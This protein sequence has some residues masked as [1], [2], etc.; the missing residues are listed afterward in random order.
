MTP[1]TTTFPT[2]TS[3]EVISPN[4][5]ITSA[6][7]SSDTTTKTTTT[8]PTPSESILLNESSPVLVQVYGNDKCLNAH[9]IDVLPAYRA[10][11]SQFATPDFSSTLEN[12]CGTNLDSKGVWYS[13]RSE[14][15]RVVRLEYELK[16]QDLGDSILSIFKGDCNASNLSCIGYTFGGD[17]W[18]GLNEVAIY[19]FLTE[20]GETYRIL[21]SGA[22]P[23]AAGNYEFR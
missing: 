19:E 6:S 22:T 13:L 3:S 15:R 12:T 20:I 5:I 2:T 14:K 10:G 8:T 4:E 11:S 23:N 7:I 21:L 1:Q 9:S 16:T 17:R 18:N